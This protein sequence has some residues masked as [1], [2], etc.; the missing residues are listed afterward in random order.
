[1][2]DSPTRVSRNVRRADHKGK[3][4]LP[5]FLKKERKTEAPYL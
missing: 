1:L 5:E 2:I 4:L 3:D